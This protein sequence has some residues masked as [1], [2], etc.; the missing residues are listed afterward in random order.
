MDEIQKLRQAVKDAFGDD[1]ARVFVGHDVEVDTRS[2]NLTIWADPEGKEELDHWSKR[3]FELTI[4]W[5]RYNLDG[6]FVIPVRWKGQWGY[7]FHEDVI[8]LGG[9]RMKITKRNA[10]FYPDRELKEQHTTIEEGTEVFVYPTGNANIYEVK[11]DNKRR[12]YMR[13]VNFR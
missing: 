9:R 12:G 2:G 1:T 5:P 13:A 7:V 3:P 11:V 4:G 10:W 6:H 8:P